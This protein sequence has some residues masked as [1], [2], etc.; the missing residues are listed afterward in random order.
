MDFVDQTIRPTGSEQMHSPS[1]SEAQLAGTPMPDLSNS[2]HVADEGICTMVTQNGEQVD[3][4]NNLIH[5]AN[6]VD[7]MDTSIH[8]GD[9]A[10]VID[11]LFHLA[12]QDDLAQSAEQSVQPNNYLTTVLTSGG[13]IDREASDFERL[14]ATQAPLPTELPYTPW[15]TTPNMQLTEEPI[16]STSNSV[17]GALRNPGSPI[18]PI[19]EHRRPTVS[20]ILMYG[21]AR[22]RRVFNGGFPPR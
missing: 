22:G 20:D 18:F 5:P 6:F 10:D 11:F 13:L 15:I 7:F 9:L 14:M 16:N 21:G 3:S 19:L 12:K 1:S 8:P 2:I 4:V 17:P